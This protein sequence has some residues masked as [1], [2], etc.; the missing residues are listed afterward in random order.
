MDDPP[1][2]PRLSGSWAFVDCGE[3][4]EPWHERLLLCFVGKRDYVVY[5]PDKDMRVEDLGCPP[6]ANVKFLGLLGGALPD[7]GLDAWFMFTP[8][9][10]SRTPW[11][12]NPR[13]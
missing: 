1:E 4:E 6:L 7:S 2:H 8:A 3:A 5:T 13:W 10:L 12:A 9:S 11:R